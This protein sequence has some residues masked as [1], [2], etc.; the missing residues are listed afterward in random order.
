MI[1]TVRAAQ[2]L[3]DGAAQIRHGGD[4]PR[5]HKPGDALEEGFDCRVIMCAGFTDA[6]GDRAGHVAITALEESR[7]V[8]SQ[9]RGF[10]RVEQGLTCQHGI[11]RRQRVGRGKSSAGAAIATLPSSDQA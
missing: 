7:L 6:G 2:Q 3:V 11:H 5:R 4:V 10:Q 8:S 9:Q 1:G